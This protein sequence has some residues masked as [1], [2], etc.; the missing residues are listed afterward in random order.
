[1]K[2][3]DHSPRLCPPNYLEFNAREDLCPNQTFELH[4][5]LSPFICLFLQL[6]KGDTYP[7][8]MALSVSSLVCS[9]LH[10]E[11][12]KLFFSPGCTLQFPARFLKHPDAGA[13]P[14]VNEIELVKWAKDSVFRCFLFLMAVGYSN[15]QQGL[16]NAGTE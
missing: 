9:S 16:I 8:T 13:P 14:P 4:L 15:L 11:S 10:L 2:V 5:P 1:M 7:V 6:N 3:L 12:M